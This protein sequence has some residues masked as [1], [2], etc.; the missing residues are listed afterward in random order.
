MYPYT[1]RANRN[2]VAKFLKDKE[3]LCPTHDKDEQKE[4]HEA[5]IQDLISKPDFVKTYKANEEHSQ[6]PLKK[7]IVNFSLREILMILFFVLTTGGLTYGVVKSEEPVQITKTQ[8]TEKIAIV[9]LAALIGAMVG[10]ATAVAYKRA[11]RTASIDT[12]YGRLIVR[13]FT[14][15]QKTSPDMFQ[16]DLLKNCNPEM[17]RV[18]S[19]ILMANMPEKD[20]KKIQE[21]AVKVPFLRDDRDINT[22]RKIEVDIKTALKIVETCLLKNPELDSLIQ[23]AYKGYI[24]TTFVLNS[25]NQKTK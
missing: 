23:Q 8:K 15:L 11:D 18:I 25:S 4:T 17:M 14:K 20:T 22:M 1:K 24:P 12:F 13:Y 2:I 9:L 6:E 3:L 21:I 19:A 5:Y 16:E 10:T 7:T